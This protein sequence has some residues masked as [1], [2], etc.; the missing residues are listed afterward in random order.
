MG[1]R[2]TISNNHR[3]QNTELHLEE[4]CLQVWNPKDDHV[5]SQ[6]KLKKKKIGIRLYGHTCPTYPFVPHHTSLQNIS[7]TLWPASSLP[8]TLLSFIFFSHNTLLSLSHP[9]PPV[10]STPP[11][12]PSFSGK[13]TRKSLATFKHLHL[14][15]LR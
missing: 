6:L 4:N 11:F 10:H 13:V 7:L 14:F 1:R 9:L 3:R 5:M 12:P 2:R 15:Y 8:L